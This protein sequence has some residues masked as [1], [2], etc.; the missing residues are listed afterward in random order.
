[1]ISL[2]TQKWIEA[3]KL[4]AE[5]PDAKI[6]CPECKRDNLEVK[7]IKNEDNIAELERIMYCPKCGAGNI[8][9]LKQ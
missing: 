9:R 1:M 6:L 4:I 2:K 8:L 5:N 7:D 3:G